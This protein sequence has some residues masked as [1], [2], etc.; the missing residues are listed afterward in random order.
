MDPLWGHRVVVLGLEEDRE[1]VSA[2]VLCVEAA[3]TEEV[4]ILYQHHRAQAHIQYLQLK[5]EEA[6]HNAVDL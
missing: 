6:R 5:L 4:E 2:G 3:V 1:V